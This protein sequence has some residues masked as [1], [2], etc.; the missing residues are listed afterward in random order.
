MNSFIDS[1]IIHLFISLFKR[2]YRVLADKV[3]PRII[4]RLKQ[5][6]RHSK[7]RI[8][9]NLPVLTSSETKVVKDLEEEIR[10]ADEAAAASEERRAEEEGEALVQRNR[11]QGMLE[12]HGDEQLGDERLGDEQLGDEQLGDDQRGDERLGD[13]ELGDEPMEAD[14]SVNDWEDDDAGEDDEDENEE[15]VNL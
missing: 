5:S 7:D 12:Q 2:K 15:N 11:D 10:V 3:R 9:L 4:R 14:E 6:R 8:V 1:L 13:D